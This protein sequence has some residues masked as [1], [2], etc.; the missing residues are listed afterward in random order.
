MAVNLSARPVA[1]QFL[2]EDEK[3]QTQQKHYKGTIPFQKGGE[4][5]PATFEQTLYKFPCKQRVGAGITCKR[6][7]YSIF[8]AI[9][10]GEYAP[11]IC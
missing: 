1:R 10:K 11:L 4:M 3:Q 9:I 5:G 7:S 2:K 6:A 8:T